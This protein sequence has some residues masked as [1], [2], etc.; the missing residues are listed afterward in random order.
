MLRE[1]TGTRISGRR[2]QFNPVRAACSACGGA[3][4]PRRPAAPAVRFVVF[5]VSFEPDRPALALEGQH[6]GGDAV[7]EPAVVADHHRASGEGDERVLERAERVHVEVVGRFV[8]QQHVGAGFQH[9]GQMHPVAFAA[10]ELRRP[11]SAGPGR[12]KLKAAHV[13]ARR[14][15]PSGAQL[16][17]V[18]LPLGRCPPRPSCPA[19]QICRATGRR[20]RARP[21]RRPCGAPPESGSSL[22]RRSCGTGWSCPRRSAPMIPT[23]APRGSL[24]LQ[25]LDQHAAHRSPSSDASRLDHQVAQAGA[26]RGSRSAPLSGA[27]SLV[28]GQQGRRRP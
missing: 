27:R 1:K 17:L 14:H 10:G 24:E 15:G 2:R 18:S 16:D 11:S 4:R 5:V 26:R 23:I 22:R 8:E 19:A 28:L 25:V 3:A 13:G 7:E 20:S 9:L 21:N 6:V 12:G